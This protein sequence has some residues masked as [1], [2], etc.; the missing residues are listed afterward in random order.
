MGAKARRP[1][2]REGRRGSNNENNHHDGSGGGAGGDARL[3]IPNQRGEHTRHNDMK[4]T[5]SVLSGAKVADVTCGGEG[6]KSFVAVSLNVRSDSCLPSN[7]AR[8][9][10]HSLKELG[11]ISGAVLCVEGDGSV[12]A[13][14]EAFCS[15]SCASQTIMLA[16][17]VAAAFSGKQV[18][19][20]VAKDICPLIPISSLVLEIT[21][22]ARIAVGADGLTSSSD[23]PFLQVC[24]AFRRRYQRRLVFRGMRAALHVGTVPYYVD[25]LECCCKSVAEGCVEGD[26]DVRQ[27]DL[28]ILIDG[29]KIRYIGRGT[30]C[31]TE[32][33]DGEP[34]PVGVEKKQ[35]HLLVL[36]DTGTGKSYF[37]R[38]EA[39]EAATLHSRQVE[40]VSVEVLSQGNMCDISSSTVLREVFVRAKAGAPSTVI[41]D[42]L[43]LVCATG[44]NGVVE[45]GWAKGLLAST[46]AS[47]LDD[48]RIR[49]LDVR[50][51]GSA[52]SVESLPRSLLT[53]D[54]FG[55]QVKLLAPGSAEERREFLQNRL[56]TFGG[57]AKVTAS[58]VSLAAESTNGFTQR[59]LVRLLDVAS[60]EAFKETGK[61]EITDSSITEAIKIV[62]PSALRQFQ[63]SIPSV[64]WSDI[65][66]SEVA[67]KT[68]QDCVAWCL[69][70]QQWVFR[71][72]NLSPPKGV[73]LYGPPGCSKTMLAKALANES[74]MNFVS[75]K[76]PE[77][78][79][80]WVG[81]SE[82]AV[83]DIFAR[84]RAAA[85]CV[86]FIDEL[87]GMCGHRGRGGVADRVISQF[88]TEL[89][90]LP[91]ALNEGTDALVFVA[92]TNRPDNIDPAVLRPGRIDRKVYVGLPD[93]NE[94]KMI[95]SIQF[96]NIPLSPELD[97]DYVAART[98]GYTGAEVVAVIK[99]AAFQCVTAGV[100]SP[101][102]STE[103]VDAALQKVRPRVS[104]MDVEWY[105]RW[106]LGQ[107]VSMK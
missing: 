31:E 36:G 106:A 86:V 67:K 93:I 77:V 14:V 75:V 87:D 74:K 16:D 101:Y 17:E 71:K 30:V 92:A 104:P 51:V 27:I 10:P 6:S 44:D 99:E 37:L 21:K 70:K 38:R 9:S 52:A 11:I 1:N 47:E 4:S 28:G 19:V 3:K 53:Y 56:K 83:R 81:D 90:G 33:F 68:L 85:P 29:S 45:S 42:D 50:V 58:F 23:I 82:K 80:K 18:T 41:I 54:R 20:S 73:L 63:V 95:A 103:N 39:H 97:A 79:S 64:K 48:I 89:D 49:Q 96:R 35:S 22:E 7:E 25:V 5:T 98:E 65:G 55:E 15:S 69:G 105:K 61:T 78:F 13:F 72:F 84:A 107:S 24:S 32:L 46:L 91:A 100:K 43:H 2:H 8:L 94:R 34:V 57:Q 12:R 62:P 59:D 60:I 26:T 102:I 40:T 88:L 76:G 66:G